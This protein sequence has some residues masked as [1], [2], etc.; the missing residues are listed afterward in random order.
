MSANEE[1]VFPMPD[2]YT[3][4]RNNNHRGEIPMKKKPA[5][6]RRGLGWGRDL[7]APAAFQLPRGPDQAVAR[8]WTVG[9]KAVAPGPRGARPLVRARGAAQLFLEVAT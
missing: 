3:R 5:N 2:Y 4:Y 1:Q 8:H 7:T 9:A 6:Q